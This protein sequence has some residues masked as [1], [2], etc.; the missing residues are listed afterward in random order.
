MDSRG[1]CRSLGSQR[2]RALL[3]EANATPANSTQQS[4]TT[5][6]QANQQ[7]K[8]LNTS[9]PGSP[10]STTS[11]RHGGGEAGAVGVQEQLQANRLDYNEAEIERRD[12]EIAN[13]EQTVDG[14]W[15]VIN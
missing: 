14:A 13:M 4:T 9:R 5:S 2:F 7:R 6:G 15:P 12:A 11:H 8:G 1:W 3:G 10:N